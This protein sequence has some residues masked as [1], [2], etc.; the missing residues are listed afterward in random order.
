MCDCGDD[1]QDLLETIH[2]DMLA[3]ATAERDAHLKQ[4]T[5]CVS[6]RFALQFVVSSC[7]PLVREMYQCVCRIL[8]V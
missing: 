7:V 2:G 1:N 3:K 5:K 6:L 4:L 8:V